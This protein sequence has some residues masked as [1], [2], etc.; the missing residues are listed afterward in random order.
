MYQRFYIFKKIY[1]I[2]FTS[3]KQ[4]TINSFNGFNSKK[5]L[6]FKHIKE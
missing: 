4:A 1:C 3:P 2:T 5:R 6:E